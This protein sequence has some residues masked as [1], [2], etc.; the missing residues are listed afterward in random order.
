MQALEP[1][2]QYDKKP[3]AA[4]ALAGGASAW[5]PPQVLIIQDT[6]GKDRLG[7]AN[8][9]HVEYSEDVKVKSISEKQLKKIM[10]EIN[11]TK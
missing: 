5:K 9:C 1:F 8:I 2:R 6:L 3:T 10:G 11:G 7:G 4:G